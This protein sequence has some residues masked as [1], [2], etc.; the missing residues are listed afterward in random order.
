[1]GLRLFLR[2]RVLRRDRQGT[3][4]SYF[5][6]CVYCR[7]ELSRKITTIDHVIPKSKGG[8]D[9]LENLVVACLSCNH[10]KADKIPESIFLKE[11]LHGENIR[12]DGGE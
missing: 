10:E 7:K 2:N 4:S 11:K 12:M 3:P 1:M 9:I 8:L 5:W 6:N